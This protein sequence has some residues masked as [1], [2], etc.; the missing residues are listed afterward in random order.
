MKKLF[1][2][3]AITIF[4]SISY[5]NQK[6]GIVIFPN[7]KYFK[8]EVADTE[9][10]MAKGLM[11]RKNL[12]KDKGMVFVYP[13]PQPSSFWMKNCFIHLDLVW[14]SEKGRI[15]HMLENVPP[16]Y[17]KNCETYQYNGNAKYVIELHHHTITRFNL[18]LGQ[19]LD[20]NIVN[21]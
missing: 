13:T 7:G 9:Q 20:L 3:L 2:L 16:C 12:D 5:A 18:K 17:G 15:L 6:Y 1:F 21:Y 14:I 8:L 10:T 19:R 4:F 11:F